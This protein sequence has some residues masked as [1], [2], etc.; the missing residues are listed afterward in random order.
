MRP[1]IDPSTILPRAG[2]GAGAP[3]GSAAVGSV[4]T[5]APSTAFVDRPN[6]KKSRVPVCNP[7]TNLS[8]LAYVPETEICTESEAKLTA[9]IPALVTGGEPGAATSSGGSVDSVGVPSAAAGSA[10]AGGATSSTGAYASAS[11]TAR[12]LRVT[13]VAPARASS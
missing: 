10:G 8:T 4:A 13:P 2:A 12:L 11:A 3:P 5:G 1:E 6:T 7:L 9:V